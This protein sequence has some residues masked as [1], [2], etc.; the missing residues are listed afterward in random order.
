MA[1][2]GRLAV[3][4]VAYPF[5][6]AGPDAIGGAEQVLSAL[7]EALV[8]AGHRS[9]VIACEGSRVHGLHVP[10]GKPSPGRAIGDAAR[11]ATHARVREGIAHVLRRERVDVV[12]LHGID[13]GAYLP[14]DGP[15]ALAT[16]HLP[17]HW[18]SPESLSPA[19]DRFFL[20]CVSEA[21]SRACP[22]NATLLPPIPNGVAVEALAA[23][24]H[25]RRGFLLTLGRICPEK[26][27]HLALEAAHA[28]QSPLLIGG[29]VFPYAAHQDYFA[30]RV[31]PLLDPTRRF[32][33]PIGFVRKRRLLAAARCVLIP[34]LAPETSSL[35][36]M[37]AAAAGTPVIAFRAGA[38]PDI[39]EHGQTGFLVDSVQAMAKAVRSVGEIDP[40][41]CR[42]AARARF[43]RETMIARYFALYARLAAA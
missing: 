40:E 32:L 42:A 1:G 10:I 27:Q 7:D 28:A 2:R 38:L 12:H 34:S 13:F 39:V 36:A 19:R 33:G 11:T 6:E 23:A 25:A 4:S 15:P 17:C 21:Q 9:I 35:V 26:G 22:P 29:A 8:R 5:A 37:E 16:L 41:I 43:R 18:Y 14:A 30:T 24:R 31:R 20:N 3:L